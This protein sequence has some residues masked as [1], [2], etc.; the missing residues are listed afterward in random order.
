MIPLISCARYWSTYSQNCIK[1][2]V[3]LFPQQDPDMKTT[4][5]LSIYH[6]VNIQKPIR[7]LKHLEDKIMLIISLIRVCKGTLGSKRP[8][9]L[10]LKITLFL[11]RG[12]V[13]KGN[14]AFNYNSPEPQGGKR[15]NC[16]RDH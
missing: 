5:S 4:C 7:S 2:V 15:Y 1:C 16:L 9:S 12:Q 13:L 8:F 11:Y 6:T 14:K 10:G 3:P